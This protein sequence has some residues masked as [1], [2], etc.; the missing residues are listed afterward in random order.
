MVA[1]MTVA[2]ALGA[3][4]SVHADDPSNH[5]TH[6]GVAS[7][8]GSNCHGALMPLKNTSVG[9]DEYEIWSQEADEHRIDK[10]HRAYAVLL[11]DLGARI[12]RNLGLPD[13]ATAKECLD[14]H[15]DN[16]PEGQRGQ[17]FRISDGV[18]CEACHGGASGWLGIHLSGAGHKANLAAG[19]YPTEQPVPRA[20][21]CLS[22]HLGTG[23]RQMTH[24]IMGAGHP[25]LPFELDTFTAIEPAH[26]EVDKRYIAEKGLPNDVQIWAVGQAVSLVHRMDRFL[27]PQNAPQGANPDLMLFDCESCHH[28]V[29]QLEWTPPGADG[30]GPGSL[31]LYDADALML[32]VIA[33][34]VAPASAAALGAHLPALHRAMREG[35]AAAVR[36]ATQLRDIATD[37]V[38][39][40]AAHDFT[41]DDMNSLAAGVLTAA[42]ADKNAKYSDMEQLTM[43]LEAIVAAKRSFGYLSDDTMEPIDRALD[44]AYRSLTESGQNRRTSFAHAIRTL[45]EVLPR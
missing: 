15:A 38:P 14:C 32:R 41:R 1:A 9:Q 6:L 31:R 25:P 43:A 13:A 12:A 37:L 29:S 18:D 30:S 10:H 20:N 42:L 45:Q 4:S 28:S 19:L 26:F 21:L 2:A 27:D 11:G 33:E 8:A 17:R 16:V 44:E 35:W 5:A 22:C 36:E 7:C 34:R 39:M 3:A 23:A 40:L 24:R